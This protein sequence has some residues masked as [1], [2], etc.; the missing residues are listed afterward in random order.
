MFHFCHE[1]LFAIMAA[2]PAFGFVVGWLRSK[3]CRKPRAC[4]CPNASTELGEKPDV[5]AGASP[6]SP[7]PPRSLG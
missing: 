1:E 6:V 4:E 3:L 7:I 5:D 2:I